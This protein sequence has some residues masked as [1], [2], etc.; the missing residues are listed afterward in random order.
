[1]LLRACHR[2]SLS[3]SL[4]L[5]L[6]LSLCAAPHPFNYALPVTLDLTCR[7]FCRRTLR[8]VGVCDGHVDM[9][10][11]NESWLYRNQTG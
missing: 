8:P 3:L 6:S 2:L 4:S 10:V 11:S 1:M 7:P 5:A 9:Q